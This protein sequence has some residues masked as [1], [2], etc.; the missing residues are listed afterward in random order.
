MQVTNANI[1]ALA[2]QITKKIPDLD[3]QSWAWLDPQHVVLT[4]TTIAPRTDGCS[5]FV[6]GWNVGFL[7]TK[8]GGA[9]MDGALPGHLNVMFGNLVDNAVNDYADK[10][11]AE[12]KADQT[13]KFLKDGIGIYHG[14]IGGTDLK[15]CWIENHGADVARIPYGEHNKIDPNQIVHTKLKHLVL[16]NCMSGKLIC[17][18]TKDR[19]EI[20][21]PE[22]QA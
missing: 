3:Q 11:F 9:L 17:T 19:I 8:N 4:K 21:S 20:T 16:E 2:E 1:E 12:Y 13:T 6:Y 5:L 7:D 14:T 15:V 18:I 10:L 22:I